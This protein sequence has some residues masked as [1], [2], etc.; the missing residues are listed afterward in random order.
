VRHLQEVLARAFDDDPAANWFCRQ[1][2]RRTERLER[3]WG[4]NLRWMSLP[5]GT[6]YT[7]NDLSGAALWSPPG[8]SPPGFVNGLRMLPDLVRATSATRLA[9]RMRGLREVERRRP[10]TQ[11]WYLQGLGTEPAFQGRGIGS[12]LLRP[13]LHEC[14]R[15]GTPAYLETAKE[16]N[17]A[18]YE[19]SGFRVVG[20]MDIPGDGPHLWLMQ[21][22]VDRTPTAVSAVDATGSPGDDADR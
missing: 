19:R 15:V 20:E 11:H 18:F 13:V 22:D 14:D 5:Y 1:D 6:A 2:G 10:R 3:M 4:F 21:R 9:S 12:A 17:I 7:T 8:E 16:G